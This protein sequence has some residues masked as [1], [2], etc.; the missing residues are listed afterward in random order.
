MTEIKN[1]IRAL[2]LSNGVDPDRFHLKL[3]PRSTNTF[4]TFVADVMRAHGVDPRSLVVKIQYESP[5]TKKTHRNKNTGRLTQAFILPTD[6]WQ[7]MTKE[8]RE[9]ILFDKNC[10][11][12]LAYGESRNKP[13]CDSYSRRNGRKYAFL[14]AWQDYESKMGLDGPR[15]LLPGT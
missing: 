2:L 12:A 6:V 1:Q 13:R 8:Q 7:P 3:T 5:H 15:K 14:K 10:P 11:L 9:A 4:D